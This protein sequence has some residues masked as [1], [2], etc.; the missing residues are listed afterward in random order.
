MKLR[1]SESLHARLKSLKRRDG[2]CV[3]EMARRALPAY[4][5]SGAPHVA[6]ASTYRGRVV[7]LPVDGTAAA[8]RRALTW[9]A[10]TK[11]NE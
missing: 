3:A 2:V 11:E 1:I 6:H 4:H 8:I 9:Y 7:T 5:A 10:N